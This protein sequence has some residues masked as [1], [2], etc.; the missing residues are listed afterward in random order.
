MYKRLYNMCIN[1]PKTIYK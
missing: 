1:H